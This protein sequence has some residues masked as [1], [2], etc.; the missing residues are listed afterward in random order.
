RV[1][2]IEAMHFEMNL[3]ANLARSW[4]AY[5]IVLAAVASTAQMPPISDRARAALDAALGVKGAYVT[6]ESAYKFTVA[7][8]DVSV[9][10]EGR[11]L[12]SEQVPASWATF[13]PSKNREAMVSGELVLL[14]DEV[15]PAIRVALT[16]GLDVTGLGPSLLISDPSLFALNVNGEGTY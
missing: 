7:R 11:R 14:A 10:I 9:R 3:S 15:N 16:S 13:A 2:S 5:A 8:N 4:K 1:D 12:S 6:E